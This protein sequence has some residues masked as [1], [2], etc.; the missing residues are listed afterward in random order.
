MQYLSQ[1]PVPQALRVM[2]IWFVPVGMA[3]AV[4][5][6]NLSFFLAYVQKGS[7]KMQCKLPICQ[8][9][10]LMRTKKDDDSKP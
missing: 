3:I 1:I 6:L 10:L 9:L 7:F 2:Y 8:I 4:K 5:K